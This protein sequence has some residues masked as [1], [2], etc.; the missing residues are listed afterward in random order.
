MDAAGSARRK[1]IRG[2]RVVGRQ[3]FSHTHNVLDLSLAAGGRARVFFTQKCVAHFHFHFH[4]TVRNFVLFDGQVTRRSSL[5]H[6]MIYGKSLISSHCVKHNLLFIFFFFLTGTHA[7]VRLISQ[8]PAALPVRARAR[9]RMQMK[10]ERAHCAK[11]ID[12]FVPGA[13]RKSRISSSSSC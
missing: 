1:A 4:F 11:A 7:R 9:A 10:R 6:F 13:S 5:S 8:L 12:R 2:W 3:L